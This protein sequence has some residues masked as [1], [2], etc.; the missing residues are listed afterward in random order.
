MSEPPADVRAFLRE[1][2]SLRLQPAGG[3]VRCALTGHELPCRLPELQAYTRGK[4]YRRLARAAP[5]FDY[6]AFEPHVVPSTKSPHQ[7]FCKLTL[8]H[9][10]KSPEHV[11]RHT[12]G[13][14][15][16]RALQKYEECQKQGVEFVPACLL[17]KRRRRED[18]QDGERPPRPREAFWEPASSDDGT[19]PGDSDDSMTDL[20]PPELFT[21]K[22]LGGT[23][24]ADSSDEFLTEDEDETPRG[25]REMGPGDSE[26]LGVGRE[27]VLKRRKQSGSLK[28]KFKSHHRK[29]KSFCS[30]KQSG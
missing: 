21:K 28:K 22:D 14:R 2:P 16:Q 26:A 7:L 23:G 6:A 10:N 12:Q 20:Y 5:A 4:K 8:R 3:K 19:A 15:Y 1:H 30:F 24:H 25:R 9:I 18:Q 27:Q 13:R 29:P 17:H 11:L